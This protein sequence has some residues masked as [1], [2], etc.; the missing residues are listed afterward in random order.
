M[1]GIAGPN[2]AGK[3]TLFNLISG[4]LAG[5]GDIILDGIKISGLRPCQICHRG[6]AR[7]FQIPQVFSSMTVLNNVKVGACFGGLKGHREGEIV[8]EVI[9]LVGLQGKENVVSD[10]LNLY[11]KRQTMLAAALA[12]RPKLLLLDEP[13]AG[14]SPTEVRETVT[15]FRKSTLS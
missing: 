14:L 5:S 2:G 12:T 15:V 11:G 1:F 6:V 10:H 13:I 9:T 7:T 4:V 3:T 8:D